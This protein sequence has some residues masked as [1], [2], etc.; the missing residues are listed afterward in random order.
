MA[1][2]SFIV[3]NS[4]LVVELN[5]EGGR[6]NAHKISFKSPSVEIGLDLSLFEGGKFVKSFLLHNIE[7]INGVEPTS[8]S[9][10][11]DKINVILA[12]VAGSGGGSSVQYNNV[13][14]YDTPANLPITFS[15]NTIH[16]ISILA[17]TGTVTMTLGGEQ[18]VLA[19]TQKTDITAT[20][21]I[22]DTIVINSTTGTFIAT[23]LTA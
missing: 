17:I 18:T 23:V 8:L 10:A 3:S 16:A 4:S 11:F 20:G 9:D 19:T 14:I 6:Y 22:S 13:D 2:Y 5:I 7:F 12:D 1:K 21:L 15:A